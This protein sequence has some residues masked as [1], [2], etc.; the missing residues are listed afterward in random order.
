MSEPVERPDPEGPR[1]LVVLALF[2]TLLGSCGSCASGAQLGTD[3]YRV[4]DISLSADEA[5]A[6][7][8]NA[9]LLEDPNTEALTIIKLVVSLML[10]G[11]GMMLFMRRKTAVWWVRNALFANM[12]WQVAYAA[13][14]LMHYRAVEDELVPIGDRPAEISITQVVILTVLVIA[15]YGHLWLRVGRLD[16]RMFEDPA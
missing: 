7:Q 10:L 13:S 2:V 16:R 9:H 3:T 1:G 5:A 8:S 15:I 12:L 11:G 6:A 14:F 4:A